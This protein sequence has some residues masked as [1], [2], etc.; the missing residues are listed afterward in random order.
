MGLNGIERWVQ[1]VKV[2]EKVTL[3]YFCKLGAITGNK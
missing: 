2:L 1:R 3:I